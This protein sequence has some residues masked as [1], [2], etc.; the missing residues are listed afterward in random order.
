MAVAQATTKAG[1][2]AEQASHHFEKELAELRRDV[3]ALARSVVDLGQASGDEMADRVH[4]LTDEMVTE[5]RRAI[6]QIRQRLN[7]VEASLEHNVRDHPMPWFLGALG[8]GV[9]L[10]LLL[11]RPT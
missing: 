8:I 5:S 11:R 9:V 3:A 6:R 1:A 2:D 4:N 7:Q 10:A